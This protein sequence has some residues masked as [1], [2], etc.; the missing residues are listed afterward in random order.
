M[1]ANK[2]AALIQATWCTLQVL[3]WGGHAG[4]AT[5]DPINH[6]AQGTGLS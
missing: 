2:H 5:G 3:Q 6:K 4:Q 1:A